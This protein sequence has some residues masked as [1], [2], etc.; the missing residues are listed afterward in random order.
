MGGNDGG[1][2]RGLHQLDQGAENV[3]GGVQVQ[4]SGRLIRQED[5]RGI[6]DGTGDRNP[7]LLTSR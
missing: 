7:L 3:L 1:E 4:I 5:A 2:A 6:G